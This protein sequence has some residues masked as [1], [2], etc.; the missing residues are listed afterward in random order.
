MRVKPLALRMLAVT[1]WIVS[2]GKLSAAAELFMA[3]RDPITRQAVE[4]VGTVGNVKTFIKQWVKRWKDK[5]AVS[6]AP[7]SGAPRKV[8]D[9]AID[10]CCA[11]FKRGYTDSAGMQRYFTSFNEAYDGHY[12]DPFIVEIVDQFGVRSVNETVF[13]RMREH[14]PDLVKVK[15]PVKHKFTDDE[16]RCRREVAR[17]FHKM[18][19]AALL[20]RLLATVWV[21]QKKGWVSEQGEWVYTSRETAAKPSFY[22]PWQR[23]A[24]KLCFYVAVNAVVGPVGL[25]H[26]TGTEGLKTR[27]KV[28]HGLK[29]GR[30]YFVVYHRN[31]TWG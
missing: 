23:K 15:Q 29:Q 20:S 13:R 30:S 10:V 9:W 4:G 18:G 14:D 17:E 24:P 6:E 2:A 12:R 16:R 19:D 8:P 22:L 21:D 3:G 27:Y 31:G 11:R 25:V 1:V 5:G 26:V 28:G 7:K